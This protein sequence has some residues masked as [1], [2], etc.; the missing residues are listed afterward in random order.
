MSMPALFKGLS[1]PVIGA[2]L[3][4]ISCPISS[5]NARPAWWIFR[6]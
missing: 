4:I 3:F 5:R 6:R 1:L 2:P